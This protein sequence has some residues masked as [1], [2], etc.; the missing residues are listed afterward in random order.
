MRK[1]EVTLAFI[2]FFILLV[3]FR[4]P[5]SPLVRIFLSLVAMGIGIYIFV[6]AIQELNKR[7]K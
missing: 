5:I 3:V 2:A 7:R 6:R 1:T 4:W